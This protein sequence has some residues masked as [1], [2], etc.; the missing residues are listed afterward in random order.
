[1]SKYKYN[2]LSNIKPLIIIPLSIFLVSLSILKILQGFSIWYILLGMVFIYMLLTWILF[3][4]G[5]P[6][7]YLDEEGFETRPQRKVNK[8]MQRIYWNNKFIRKKIY[9]KNIIKVQYVAFFPCL[10][11]LYVKFNSSKFGERIKKI[12]L[13]LC[14]YKERRKLLKEILYYCKYADIDPRINKDIW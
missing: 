7:L 13:E 1:M 10:L 4:L 11:L 8:V 3:L 14:I 2:I 6:A 12:R 5:N 9:W